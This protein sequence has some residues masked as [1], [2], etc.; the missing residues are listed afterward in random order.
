MDTPLSLAR[1]N[2]GRTGAFALSRVSDRLTFLYVDKCRIEQDENGTHARIEIS[3]EKGGGS[4]TTYLP[5]ATIACLMLGP[6]TSISAPASAACARNGCAVVFVG[7]GA[8]RGYSTWSPL[9]GSTK[10][11]EAQARA[12][13]NPDL[14][15]EVAK[16]MFE[17]RFPDNVLPSGPI[18]LEELRG[19]EGAR[20][21]AVYKME[22]RRRRLPN[23]RRRHNDYD[24]KGPLDP[25]NEALNHAN[26]AMYGLCLSV[27]C[28]LGMSPGLGIVHSGN[29]RSFVLDI[30]DLYKAEVTLPA[31]FRCAGSANPGR[32]VMYALRDDFRLLRILP[33]IVNDIQELFGDGSD[34]TDWDVD[35]LSL[36]NNAGKQIIAGWNRHGR[37]TPPS[38]P[39]QLDVTDP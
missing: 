7:S 5:T 1:P 30:A 9:S 6:G 34:A 16:R 37:E 23:W 29:Q 14:R 3:E 22:A 2:Q 32:D 20:M 24:G 36:W 38:P 4:L 26:T 18:S 8:V 11:L 25:V 10:L 35:E 21:K 13:S 33:R 15:V 39:N 17:M 31:A 12:S 28:A 27:I 19:L